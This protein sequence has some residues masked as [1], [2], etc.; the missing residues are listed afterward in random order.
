[1]LIVVVGL[2]VGWV[3]LVL[4]LVGKNIVG[5]ALPVVL[6]YQPVCPVHF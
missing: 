3:L 1:M 5:R 2:R 6:G 4:V